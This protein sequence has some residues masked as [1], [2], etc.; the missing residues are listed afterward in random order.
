MSQTVQTPTTQGSQLHA[1]P[2][3][4]EA[5]GV[6]R[7]EVRRRSA[8]ITGPR[9]GREELRETYADLLERAKKVR[10]RE[11]LYPYIGSGVGNGALVELADG[12]VK[13]DMICGIGVHFFG[14]SDEE[15]IAAGVEGALEDTLQNGNLQTNFEAYRFGETLLA[16]ASR[17]T[18]LAHCYASPTGALA[19]EN[20]LKVCYQKHAPASRVLAFKDCFMGRT[21]T[22]SQIGDAAANRVGLPLST[23]VDYVPFYS[24]VVAERVGQAKHIGMVVD[25]VCSYVER[26]PR[27]HACFVMELVQGEGGFNTAPREFF[28]ALVEVCR[29]NGIAV[30]ADEVQTFGRTTAMFAAEALGIGEHVDVMTVGKMSQVCATLYTP[31]Y[32]PGPGLLSATFTGAGPAFTVGRRIIERLRDGDYYGPGGRI[33][34]HHAAFREQVRALAA[35]HPQWFPPV[36]DGVLTPAPKGVVGGIGGMMRFSPFGGRKERITKACRTCFDEG[37]ILFSCGHGPYH[38]R[39]LPP[40][41]VMRLE[42]WP[43]VFEC[44]ERGL[45]KA[46]S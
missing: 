20:A 9:A 32:N 37:V 2:A 12:S 11:L 35:K 39:M 4:R 1:S 46:A 29:A 42:D 14:H 40:L 23:L 5:I 6:L 34:Q 3:V 44:V 30:W 21:V 10:G 24:E 27:Q 25:H 26:Y 13:W 7:E 22:L 17:S 16:E 33:A 8:T 31:E 28:L 15:L 38:L 19:N 36:A 41:G 18:R 43:R 45:A